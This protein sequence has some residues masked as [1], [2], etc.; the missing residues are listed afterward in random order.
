MAFP[1]P[2]YTNFPTSMMYTDGGDHVNQE[3]I[4]KEV[5]RKQFWKKDQQNDTLIDYAYT[6][7]I[8]REE[9]NKA[10]IDSVINADGFK[11]K[12][13]DISGIAQGYGN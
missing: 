2:I 9:Q 5:F 12:H 13:A 11:L 8:K 3:N 4:T 10:Q 1:F 7:F 6:E